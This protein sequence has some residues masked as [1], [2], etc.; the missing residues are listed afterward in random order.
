MSRLSEMHAR[1]IEARDLQQSGTTTSQNCVSRA[2]WLVARARYQSR[3]SSACTRVPVPGVHS[4]TRLVSTGADGRVVVESHRVPNI[5]FQSARHSAHRNLKE[6][7]VRILPFTTRNDREGDSPS[8]AYYS[9]VTARWPV[10]FT[11]PR[12]PVI[13]GRHRSNSALTIL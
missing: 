3:I 7:R 13:P 9:K 11:S 6:P 12:L 1:Y 4:G 2:S 10:H 5:I 8:T